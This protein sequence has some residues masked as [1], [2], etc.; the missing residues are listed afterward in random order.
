MPHV[1]KQHHIDLVKAEVAKLSGMEQY[2][3]IYIDTYICVCVCVVNYISP[4]TAIGGKRFTTAAMNKAINFK[5][6]KTTSTETSE[7]HLG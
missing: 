6:S 2:I 3:Y 5:A 7:M 4:N 1:H